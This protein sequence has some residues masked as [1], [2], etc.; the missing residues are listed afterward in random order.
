MST[1]ANIVVSMGDSRV[2]LYRHCDGYLAE[3]GADLL[4]KL[5]AA[6]SATDFL[7]AVCSE[8]YEKQ[9]YER[10]ARPVY[11]FTNMLH[12]DIEHVYYISF[13]AV[14]SRGGPK[15]RHAARPSLRHSPD[16]PQIVWTKYGEKVSLAE[17]AEAVNQDR[18]ECNKRIKQL[19]AEQPAAYADCDEYEMV[20][21]AS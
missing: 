5:R 10:A 17:F 12:G 18:S 19:K 7:R 1:R 14:R 16:V 11:E 13:Q 3:T 8:M 2:F 4:A 6:E 15:V 21:V 20:E 9:S